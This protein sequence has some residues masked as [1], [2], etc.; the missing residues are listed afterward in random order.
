[1]QVRISNLLFFHILF[2]HTKTNTSSITISQLQI[3]AIK[4]QIQINN[5][6]SNFQYPHGISNLAT[7]QS[8]L[9]QRPLI[10]STFLLRKIRQSSHKPS[11]KVIFIVCRTCTNIIFLSQ[12]FI[13]KLHNT[14]T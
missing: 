3:H 6:I 9:L 11:N 10:F 4:P 14:K 2:I 7:L 13:N 1:V 12:K 5:A 8:I